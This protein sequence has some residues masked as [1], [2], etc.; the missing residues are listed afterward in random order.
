MDMK[1]PSNIYILLWISNTNNMVSGNHSGNKESI[2]LISLNPMTDNSY[3][4]QW[5][6]PPSHMTAEEIYS[7][8]MIGNMICD[9]V[10]LMVM[11]LFLNEVKST[12]DTILHIIS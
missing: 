2:Q 6:K 4:C 11:N 3:K 12:R 7:S 1:L 5:K 9:T 10:S 8:D